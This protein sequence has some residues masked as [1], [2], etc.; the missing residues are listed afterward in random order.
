ML[1]F[2][3][4]SLSSLFQGLTVNAL[5]ISSSSLFVAAVL[6][7]LSSGRVD[8][9]AVSYL[10]IWMQNLQDGNWKM[11]SGAR[12]YAAYTELCP[13]TGRFVNGICLDWTTNDSLLVAIP[14]VTD[15]NQ[16]VSLVV[17]SAGE[18]L[19]GTLAQSMHNRSQ[20]LVTGEAVVSGI[21]VLHEAEDF[22]AYLSGESQQIFVHR[23][24]IYAVLWSQ[25]RLNLL[26]VNLNKNATSIVWTNVSRSATHA[27]CSFFWYRKSVPEVPFYRWMLPTYSIHM[28]K[29]QVPRT[30]YS[31]KFPFLLG[32]MHTAV[33]ASVC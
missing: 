28:P 16:D 4:D 1:R 5:S 8:T 12:I 24:M 7:T 14:S 11:I 17:L 2:P 22:L 26:A 18:L 10:V 13:P 20:R 30:K 27:L 31:V 3:R 25:L 23:E 29:A 19:Q 6:S 32:L 9:P 33:S 15:S 21:R